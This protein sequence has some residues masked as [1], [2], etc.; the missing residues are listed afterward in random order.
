MSCFTLA[1][2]F[3]GVMAET[4]T[5]FGTAATYYP[6]VLTGY[7]VDA[8]DVDPNESAAVT[9]SGFM[10]NKLMR[11]GDNT[12]ERLVTF[13]LSA[14]AGVTPKPLDR[15]VVASLSYLV[16]DVQVV[17]MGADVASYNLTLRA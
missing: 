10:V 7:D 4:A 13:M 16:S 12:L 5:L 1:D 2:A 8:A 15:L 14:D 9:V 6:S 11:A 3:N 17:M